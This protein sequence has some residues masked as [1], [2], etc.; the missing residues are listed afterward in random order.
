MADTIIDEPVPSTQSEPP[1]LRPRPK[2]APNRRR[3]AAV[4][5]AISAAVLLVAGL[6]FYLF[7][8]RY[9]PLAR[10]HI[11]GNANIAVHVELREVAFFGPVRKHLWPLLDG[12]G[13]DGPSLR[14]RTGVELG[15]DV[16]ELLLASADGKSWVLIAGGKIKKGKFVRGL[17]EAAAASNRGEWRLDGDFLVG[18]GGVTVAQADDGTILVGT[19]KAIVVAALPTSD[20]Y[21]R[22]ALPE[23]GA[24]TFA[25]THLAWDGASGFLGDVVKHNQVLRQVER[26]TGW[27]ELG[28]TPTLV[29][30]VE[31][32]PGN[33]PAAL[34]RDL[35]VTLG[36]LRL[37]TLLVPDVAGE[38]AALGRAL[39]RPEKDG[40]VRV[41]AS[42]PYDGLDRGCA[43]LVALLRVLGVV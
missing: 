10:R 34:A 8:I 30:R 27:L 3:V 16:R 42:W 41:T 38:K 26:A 4:A 22:L 7:V 14:E 24:V 39:V 20:E 32:R 9:E 2:K 29:I 37:L 28:D 33:E 21:K 5:A 17:H 36:E 11:P 19:D 13:K 18:P 25:V 23:K 12:D 6:A 31:P 43:R 35:E 1:R 15:A 40:S